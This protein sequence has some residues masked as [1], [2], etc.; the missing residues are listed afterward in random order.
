MLLSF[1]LIVLTVVSALVLFGCLVDE[2]FG[3]A[4]VVAVIVC[5]LGS[6]SSMSLR[7]DD[8]V[9]ALE[10]KDA[11]YAQLETHA[12]KVGNLLA[13][14]NTELNKAYA[15]ITAYEGQISNIR[16]RLSW[17]DTNLKK[18]EAKQQESTGS[19]DEIRAILEN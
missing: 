3:F 15:R 13:T 6:A 18:C 4:F 14:K 9:A 16:T 5:V 19:I 11:Q 8:A 10:A 12:A 2:D 1:F 7:Y 17:S